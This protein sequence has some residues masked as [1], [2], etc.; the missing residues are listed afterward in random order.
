MTAARGETS[1]PAN[2]LLNLLKAAASEAQPFEAA[3][4]A[5][6]KVAGERIASVFVIESGLVAMLARTADGERAETALLGR[7]AL[8]GQAAWLGAKTA[9]LDAIALTKV[10]GLSVK[11]ADLRSAAE[12]SPQLRV[13]LTAHL[14]K[15]LEDTERICACAALHS[16]ERRLANWLMR[17]VALTGG[18][19]VEVTHE[20]LAI[21]LGVRRASVTVALHMLEGERAVSC[22]RGRIDIR[23]AS[24][25]EALAC[26]C[27]R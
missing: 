7:D 21:V 25:L 9:R 10:R 14:L 3:A 26:G 1:P 17:A 8:I 4:G 20:R 19:P 16:V 6:L 5:T 15:R 11:A 24:R 18:L 22:R 23:N 27:R 2:R 13:A 12:A